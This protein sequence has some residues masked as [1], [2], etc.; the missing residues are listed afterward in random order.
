L[1]SLVSFATTNGGV[2]EA[3]LVLGQDGNFYGTTSWGGPT[4][5]GNHGTVFRVSPAGLLTT[6]VAFTGPNGAAPYGGL[7]LGNDGSFYGTTSGGGSGGNG[8][9]FR[10]SPD[11]VLTTLVSF[12]G[13]NGA[14]PHGDL[15]FGPDG[16]LY[17]LT[18]EGGPGGGGTVFRVPIMPT[19]TGVVRQPGGSMLLTGTGLPNQTCQLWAGRYVSSPFSSWVQLASGSFDSNGNC[20]FTDMGAPTNCSCFYRLL[21]P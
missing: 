17:G 6:L 9:V 7:V 14:S 2:P 1:T 3:G 10:M 16:N 18:T 11:G 4:G 8:T 15:A 5:A 19:L 12:S 20:A 13:P 21:V